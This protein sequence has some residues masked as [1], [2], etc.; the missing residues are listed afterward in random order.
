MKNLLI[1]AVVIALLVFGKRWLDGETSSSLVSVTLRNPYPQSS[2][3]YPASQGFVDSINADA[4]L[5]SRFAGVFTK[6]GLYS[7]MRAALQRGARSL[8]GP[9]LV[10]AMTAMAR[11]LPHMDEHSCAESF[12]ERDTFDEQLSQSVHDAM[13][14]IDP[15]YHAA[16]MR[17]YLEALKAE[18]ADAP[19]RAID[20]DE[21]TIA[22]NNLGSQFQGEFAN[23][24]VAAMS[25]KSGASDADLCWAGKTLLHSVTQM[26]GRDREVLS[27]WG[28]GGK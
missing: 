16:L 9:V 17:F 11:A 7:E 22:M 1:V 13:E 27:R 19:E 15:I 25:N 28:L 18:V 6:R 14:Q 3:L 5:K 4:R 26:E 2:P 23:R 8:D 24:F 10:G 20:K 12:R 21:L